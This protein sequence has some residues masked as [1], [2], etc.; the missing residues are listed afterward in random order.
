[1]LLFICSK[2][3]A[4]S[5]QPVNCVCTKSDW[6]ANER[7]FYMCQQLCTLIPFVLI[8][9][10]HKNTMLYQLCFDIFWFIQ[11]KTFFRAGAKKQKSSRCWL[12]DI[13]VI[14]CSVSFWFMKADR[15]QTECTWR[16][17]D[18]EIALLF[19]QIVLREFI[20]VS[21]ASETRNWLKWVW[22]MSVFK[23]NLCVTLYTIYQFFG[24]NPWLLNIVHL[25]EN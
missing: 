9:P 3:G 7:L 18:N 17:F 24:A 5:A 11:L 4:F 23:R 8:K 6:N 13:R 1:M 25:T 2:R 12:S 15:E 10:V 19:R 16:M 20:F 21:S 22:A 14:L